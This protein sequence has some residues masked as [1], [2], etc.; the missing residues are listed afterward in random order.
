MLTRNVQL[1]AR[2]ETEKAGVFT[3][4][5][6]QVIAGITDKLFCE[7]KTPEFHVES[8]DLTENPGSKN[9]DGSFLRDGFMAWIPA[10]SKP[11]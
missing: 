9:R 1:G 11:E 8:R 5:K 10:K 4:K 7:G 3:N 2:T 6:G